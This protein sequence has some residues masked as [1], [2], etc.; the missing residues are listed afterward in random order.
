MPFVNART[1]PRSPRRIASTAHPL[2]EFIRK[3]LARDTRPG[4]RALGIR[5]RHAQRLLTRAVG[6]MTKPMHQG[7]YYQH[8]VR[9][10][11]I[12]TGPLEPALSIPAHAVSDARA[13]A[14]AA[15]LGRAA[16][17]DRACARRRVRQGQA[18]DSVARRSSRDRSRAR[19]QERRASLVG[20]RGDAAT[21][22]RFARRRRQTAS[23]CVLDLAGATTLPV[24]AGVISLPRA[25]VS[26]DSGAMHLAAAA[27][28][29][30][31]GIFGSTNEQAT[32]PLTARGRCRRSGHQSCVVPP[33]YASGVPDR[34]P[35]HDRH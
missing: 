7:E 24:L 28:V 22:A 30:V 31:V 32:S 14:G 27:G 20:S 2:S 26:N 33:L 5:H 1:Q 13:L 18:M 10:L 23:A 19:P 9:E 11:G 17:A 25:C 34:S 29:A 12:A 35:L 21:T 3:R 8:L 6:R 4:P 16:G 15:W